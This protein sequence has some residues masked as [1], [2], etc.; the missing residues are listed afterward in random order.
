MRNTTPTL[1]NWT[2]PQKI[3]IK[4]L[5]RGGVHHRDMW[6]AALQEEVTVSPEMAWMPDFCEPVRL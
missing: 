6:G 5:Q 3:D 1:R 2:L 4:Y